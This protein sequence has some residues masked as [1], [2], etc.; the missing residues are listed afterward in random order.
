[1]DFDPT[2]EQRAIVDRVRAFVDERM[3][4]AEAEI[5]DDAGV[6]AA[7]L[8]ELQDAA[9][10]AGLWAPDVR[11]EHGGLGL[12][13][14]TMILAEIEM[15]RSLFPE[16]QQLWVFGV[17]WMKGVAMLYEGSE[18]QKARYLRP[19]I[20]GEL[21]P[22]YGLTEPEAG[23]DATDL[24]TTAVRQGDGYM[25]NGRKTLASLTPDAG[26]AMVFATTDP[27]KR[28]RGGI[29]CILV[30]V[31]TP[32]FT[33]SPPIRT[34]GPRKVVE[35]TFQDC[36]VPLTNLLGQEGYG[37]QLGMDWVNTERLYAGAYCVGRGGRLVEMALDYAERRVTF[38]QP[39]I[40]R[41]AVQWMLADSLIDL[42]TVRWIT[43]QAA[44]KADR[45][46]DI[47][48]ESAI[49]K[50][51]AAA[52]IN[53]VADRAL[54]VFGGYGYTEQLPIERV[55]REARTYRIEDGTDEIQR[56]NMVR[57]LRKGWR[58]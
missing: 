2:P 41:Q 49:V 40:E 34:M 8:R 9:R 42:H 58:A 15:T 52:A 35:L 32:G 47:R 38:G 13:D 43:L 7:R 54:Q 3:I 23:S 27:E 18:E 30:D 29:S 33:V 50:A 57:G 48:T 10:S 19:I 46:Q 44:W 20:A 37:F 39:I 12:D 22:Y 55:Y 56:I 11:R 17:G 25:I 51:H 26:F 1:M 6:S 45:K 31:G 21:A 36:R 14:T 4:P 24:K 28:S 53:R 5:T 16:Y